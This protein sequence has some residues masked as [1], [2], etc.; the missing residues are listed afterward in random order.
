MSKHTLAFCQGQLQWQL[1]G[2]V[3]YEDGTL[4][5]A[6]VINGA[7]HLKR[8]T[9]GVLTVHAHSDAPRAKFHGSPG[10]QGR[11]N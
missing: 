3:Y 5:S 9:D 11:R 1:G 4:A 8:S 7:W 2:A 6:E 10:F